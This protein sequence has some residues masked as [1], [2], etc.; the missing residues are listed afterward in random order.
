[1][2]TMMTKIDKAKQ[3]C[4]KHVNV[5]SMDGLHIK[6]FKVETHNSGFLLAAFTFVG[7]VL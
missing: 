5:T 6:M 7:H 3:L 4:H 2:I 1:M